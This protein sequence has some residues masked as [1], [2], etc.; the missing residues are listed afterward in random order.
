MRSH[1]KVADAE[2]DGRRDESPDLSP[3]ADPDA[4]KLDSPS[5]LDKHSW[6]YVLRK[7]IREFSDD[8]CTDLAAALTYYSVLA[9]FPAVVALT[10]VLGLVDQGTK[11]VET[12]LAQGAKGPVTVVASHGLFVGPAR[13]RLAAR[14]RS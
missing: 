6:H 12:V 10:S 2:P 9:L 8:E 4:G 13:E 5:D 14:L 11:A 3:E 1:E 7:T